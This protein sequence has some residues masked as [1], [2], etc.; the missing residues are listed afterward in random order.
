MADEVE[1]HS[2]EKVEEERDAATYSVE[3]FMEEVQKYPC[4][5]DKFSKE[6]KDKFKKVNSWEK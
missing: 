4:L 3:G 1:M 5:Y 6:F 2:E